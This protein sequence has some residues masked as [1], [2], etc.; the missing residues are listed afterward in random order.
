MPLKIY[1]TKS[2]LKEDFKPIVPGKV[3][4]YVCGITAYDYCHLGHARASVVFDVLYRYLKHKGFEVRYVRN[5][6][7]ID[8]KILK[9]SQE[10]GQDWRE[11]KEFFIQAFHQDME[12]LGNLRPTDE[13][14]ATEYVPQMLSL[15]AKLVEK[16]IAYPAKGDVFYAV[17]KF[18]GYGELSGKN[19]ED[20]EAGARVEVQ[21]AKNDPLDFALWKGAKPGE[22]EWAS[23]WGP[24][25]PGWHIECSAMSTDILG[26]SIDIHGGGRD[27]IF[28]HHENEKAQSEGALEKPFVN[29]W[30]HNGFVNL[31][32]DKMS[33]STGNFLT[34]RDVLAEYPHEAI[35]YFLLSAHYRSP[36]D[37][38]ESNMREAVGAVDRVYQTLARLEEA[39]AGK[40]AEAQGKDAAFT[41]LQAF[42]AGFE[43]AMD[44]DFNSAQVL[45]LVFELVRE[46]NRFLDLSPAP[47]QIAAFREGLS[48]AL[49]PVGESLGLFHQKP[50][51]YFESRKR[52]TLKASSLSEAEILG[53]I[54][55]RKAARQN[56]DF[57]KADRIR[58][59]LSARGVILEDKPDGTTLWK[60]K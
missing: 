32:A 25:R 6:T 35:R 2:R 10:K 54:E 9:R 11:L 37:F 40:Q 48:R 1:N 3:G 50:A 57:K 56:K 27:L 17:R 44:D 55:E 39:G 45:G 34:I 41:V 7:D 60:A 24:G 5:F 26:P 33:K 20:L 15:I 47:G 12:A 29:Y 51:A 21:E 38:N 4:M 14:K 59:D 28:P 36:L 23:P 18:Q 30:V 8:D 46:T 13:P 31:N 16:G 52:F 49:K 43:A 53:Q 19:I 42:P 22:P 58:D